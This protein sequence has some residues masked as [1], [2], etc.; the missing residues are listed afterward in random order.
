MLIALLFLISSAQAEWTR[1][2][3]SNPLPQRTEFYIATYLHRG[4]IDYAIVSSLFSFYLTVIYDFS[5]VPVIV[6]VVTTPVQL[7]DIQAHHE[8]ENWLVRTESEKIRG[9]SRRLFI[10]ASFTGDEELR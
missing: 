4:P 6:Y 2:H 5:R 3:A 8:A 1:V 10:D 7:S 9:I